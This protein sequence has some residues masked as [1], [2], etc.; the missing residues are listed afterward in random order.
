[1]LRVRIKMLSAAYASSAQDTDYTGGGGCQEFIPPNSSA[2]HRSM[3]SWTACG[4][5]GR[6]K[7]AEAKTTGAHTATG[8]LPCLAIMVGVMRTHV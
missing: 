1:M 8:P 5:G 3:F 7:T 6:R 2:I 4:A